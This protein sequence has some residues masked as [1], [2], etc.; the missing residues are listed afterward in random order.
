MS[1]ASLSSD[2]WMGWSDQVNVP[3]PATN[4]PQLAGTT[5]SS[6]AVGELIAFFFFFLFLLF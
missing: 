1:I 2:Q 4:K 5:H 6:L 3:A